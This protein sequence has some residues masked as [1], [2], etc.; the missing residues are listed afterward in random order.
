MNR[1]IATVIFVIGAMFWS[2]S[3]SAW[4][5]FT[6][7]F[8]GS[9]APCHQLK[10][11]TCLKQFD[12]ATYVTCSNLE[13]SFLCVFTPKQMLAYSNKIALLKSRSDSPTD[14]PFAIVE[15]GAGKL[16]LAFRKFVAECDVLQTR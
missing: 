13:D 8:G 10:G 6:C 16:T 1:V 3:A 7:T 11:G 15:P 2:A 12:S 9:D 4:E 14:Y 5:S